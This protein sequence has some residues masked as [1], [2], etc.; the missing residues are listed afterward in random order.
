MFETGLKYLFAD[1]CNPALNVSLKFYLL[2]C[3]LCLSMAKVVSPK[4]THEA[5]INTTMHNL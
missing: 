5:K 1:N 4:V 3:L 2:Q